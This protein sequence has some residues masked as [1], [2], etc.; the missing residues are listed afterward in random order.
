MVMIRIKVPATSANLGPGFDVVGLALSL[1]NVYEV[2]S[3]DAFQ[4]EGFEPSE[5]N[6]FLKAYEATF[7]QWGLLANRFPIRVRLTLSEVPMSRGLGSSAN[8]IVAGVIAAYAMTNTP[9]DL[10]D[11]LNVAVSVEGHPDNVSAAVYGGLTSVILTKNGP[12]THRFDVAKSLHFGLLIPSTHGITK[13]LRQ[14]L[15][16]HLSYPQAVANLGRA[17]QLPHAWA[18]GNIDWIKEVSFDQWH[19]PYRKHAI[20]HYETIKRMADEHQIVCL[21]S[22]S[23]PTLLLVSDEPISESFYA[24]AKSLGDLEARTVNPVSGVTW[25]E[26]R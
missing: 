8:L 7:S 14:A 21:I 19:E 13:A 15:P 23:G 22:G 25:E 11:V 24:K 26:D 5:D 6:L 10:R 20:P 4:W 12:L 1:W 18:S 17:F 3:G 2:T 16:D 9:I